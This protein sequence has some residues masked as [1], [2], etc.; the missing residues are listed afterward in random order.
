MRHFITCLCLFLSTCVLSQKSTALFLQAQYNST[1]YDITEVNNP[2]GFGLGLQT[3]FNNNGKIKPTVEATFDGYFGGLKVQLLYPDDTPIPTV[4]GMFNLF[5]GA[6]WYPFKA[7]FISF[8]AGPSFISGG[9]F[10]GIKPAIGANFGNNQQWIGKL[11]LINI[12]NRDARTNE[13]FGSISLSL[14]LRLF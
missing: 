4:D 5:A 11:A 13:D 9:T 2:A 7:G 3:F 6:S 12:Y 8:T 10:W 1:L 14:G